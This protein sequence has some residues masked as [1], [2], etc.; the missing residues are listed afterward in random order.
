M[1]VVNPEK[2][3][4]L[5]RNPEGIRNVSCPWR[6]NFDITADTTSRFAY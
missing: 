4:A 2:L 6:G 3:V 5:Q 1:P